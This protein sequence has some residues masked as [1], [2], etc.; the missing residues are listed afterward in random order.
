MV[1]ASL[2]ASKPAALSPK[3]PE[4][5]ARLT[6]EHHRR[7]D[8]GGRAASLAAFAARMREVGEQHLPRIVEIA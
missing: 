3:S 2:I 7:Q 6:E 1:R 8:E 4:M 5:R